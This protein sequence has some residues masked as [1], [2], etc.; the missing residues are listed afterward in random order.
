MV[1]HN[2]FLK[3]F[4]YEKGRLCNTLV[5]SNFALYTTLFLGFIPPVPCTICVSRRFLGVLDGIFFHL[6]NFNEFSENVFLTLVYHI[7]P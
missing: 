4:F 1:S 6:F 7:N 3:E 2:T 5:L